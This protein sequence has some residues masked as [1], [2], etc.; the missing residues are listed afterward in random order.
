MEVE[1]L[2]LQVDSHETEKNHSRVEL[3]LTERKEESNQ[4]SLE[5]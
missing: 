4:A 2:R 3:L 5:C 1:K